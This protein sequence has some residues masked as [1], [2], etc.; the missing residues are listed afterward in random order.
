M[1][2]SP[3][4][5]PL[6]V[7]L[8]PGIIYSPLARRARVHGT[9]L[10]VWEIIHVYRLVGEDF[11]RLRQ[12]FDWLTTEQLQAALIFAERN[13]AFIASELAEVDDTPRRLEALWRDYPFTMPTHRR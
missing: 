12:S 5:K 13:P 7:E 4:P 8:V 1:T 3:R 6:P 2:A 11:D 9:G 10:E